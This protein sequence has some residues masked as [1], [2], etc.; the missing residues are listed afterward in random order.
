MIF[1]ADFNK[2][3]GTETA[4]T[5]K[6]H[7]DNYLAAWN[8][9]ATKHAYGAWHSSWLWVRMEAQQELVS[10][11]ISVLLL[12][13]VLAFIGMLIFTLDPV[14]SIYVVL[15]TVGV[16]CG[17]AFFIIV[18][19]NW[20]IG[21][22]E[23]IALIV[24]TGYAVTYSLHIAHKY[25][26][27]EGVL[28]EPMPL[29]MEIAT[30]VRFQRTSYAMKSI[31]GAAIG[32]AVTTIGCSIFLLFCTL[33]IF[34]KLGMVVLAVTTMSIVTALIPLP[35]VLLCAGPLQPGRF[36]VACLES[37]VSLVRLTGLGNSMESRG[38]KE[39]R[40]ASDV[41]A[42]G[43]AVVSPSMESPSRYTGEHPTERPEARP[44]SFA[45]THD[46]DD[47]SSPQRQSL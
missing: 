36:F 32:S 20:N 33:T 23:V 30:A 14:L 7:W 11:T 44:V 42:S 25:S 40:M 1:I 5:Y 15:A 4:S 9:G 29:D 19:M 27:N 16:M 2:N 24:F 39:E 10:S 22:I 37:A 21:P 35:A 43:A 26:S 6:E 18:V 3:A 47:S 8:K 12:V 31:A 38:I 46:M 41:V 13:V 34:Q 45:S 28:T 17:L